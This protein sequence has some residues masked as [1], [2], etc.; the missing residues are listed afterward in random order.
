MS[1][2]NKLPSAVDAQ[3][4]RTRKTVKLRS[5]APITQDFPVSDPLTSR[6]TDTGNLEILDDTQTRKTLKLKPMVPGASAGP[7][8]NI[9]SEDTN[10]RKTVILRP[11]AQ[12]PPVNAAP[13]AP[14]PPVIPGGAA[15]P[16]PVVAP[17]VNPVAAPVN[18]V[19]A[20]A[21]AAPKV[22]VDDQTRAVPRPA[23]AVAPK[24]E[25]DDQTRA[26]PRP[27]VAAA[28]KVEVDDQ[29]RAVPRPMAAP[30]GV[31]LPASEDD[32]NADQTVKMK[33]PP[34]LTPTPMAPGAQRPPVSGDA[35]ATVKLAPPP[36]A[37]PKPP[38]A[39]A[40][41]PA[42]APK[43]PVAPAAPAPAVAAPKPPTAAPKPPT[44]APKPPTAAPKPPTAAPAAASAP[45][46]APEKAPEAA[47]KADE[48][49]ALAP[50]KR[51]QEPAEGE[52]AEKS[53]KAPVSRR[54]NDEE[55]EN[56]PSLFYLIIAVATLLFVAA[57]GVITTV[58]YL[59]FE[60]KIQIYDH[61]PG[62]PMAK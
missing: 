52:N 39:S 25:V 38:V 51:K 49:I 7:K 41:A 8:L 46:K 53:P 18:P 57:A 50:S 59:D 35:K 37:A 11:A 33:R 21:V 30:G 36:A 44:A 6:D 40:A 43:P 4:T 9:G 32:A 58:H 24:V 29:T 16:A 10:T 62:L 27:A 20:P 60:H 42:A 54:I 31:K 17:P 19:P 12:V 13:A 5:A 15:A 45:E 14:K 55:V 61:V 28:P 2:E 1:E 56:K 48:D 23:V 22:E 26:V 47:P 3:D 34:R